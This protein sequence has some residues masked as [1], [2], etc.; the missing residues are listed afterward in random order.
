MR[1]PH[2][3]LFMDF[4]GSLVS[5]MCF[6]QPPSVS[7]KSNVY[8]IL[9]RSSTCHIHTEAL[10]WPQ[11]IFAS[12]C[13]SDHAQ[14]YCILSSA[15]TSLERTAERCVFLGVRVIS[16]KFDFDV[17]YCS[18]KRWSRFQQSPNFRLVKGL[19]T[20]KSIGAVRFCWVF[21]NQYPEWF[22]ALS[23]RT[24]S[25][26]WASKEVIHMLPRLPHMC[27]VL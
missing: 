17:V 6:G 24:I 18:C 16:H 4:Q 14:P 5:E 23:F 19:V 3:F 22:S 11:C 13:C 25:T 8:C 1:D 21:N 15:E 12:L 26:F 9:Q 27:L 10:R 2:N 7:L 20:G